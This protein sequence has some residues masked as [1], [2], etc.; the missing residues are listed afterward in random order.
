MFRLQN[1]NKPDLEPGVEGN[2]VRLGRKWFDQVQIGNQIEI[3]VGSGLQEEV[4]GLGVV[5]DLELK[6]FSSLTEGEI[7]LNH[8]QGARTRIGLAAAMVQ[9]YGQGWNPEEEVT[10]LTYK[11]LASG[12]TF[13]RLSG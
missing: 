10:V 12:T 5:T 1:I 4:I 7:A 11:R 6:R 8:K 9:A 13:G 2:T 3:T